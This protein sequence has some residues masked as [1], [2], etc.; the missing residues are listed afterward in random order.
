[1]SETRAT[2][3]RLD[4]AA[5]IA[6]AILTACGGSLGSASDSVSPEPMASSDESA[7]ALTP[8]PQA[9]ATATSTLAPMLM[10]DDI[11]EVVTNDLVVRSLPEISDRSTIDEIRLNQEEGVLLFVLDGPVTADG[12]DW[13]RVAPF[14]SAVMD[15]LPS[16]LPGIGWVAAGRQGDDWIAPW[17]QACREPTVYDLL[18]TVPLKRLA[19]FGDRELTF[20]GQLGECTYVV[21]GTTSPSW[22]TTEFCTLY[23]DIPTDI[24]GPLHFHLDP[25]FFHSTPPPGLV[26]VTGIFDHPAAQTCEHHPLA[27]EEARP[28]EDVV[29]GCRAAFVATS[30]EER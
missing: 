12:F 27:G 14:Y 23:A 17:T 19:C 4:L 24:A 5:V 18:F 2:R 9:T 15:I 6:L 25:D 11:A 30:V 13:Y 26:R 16:P 10:A 21:P 3:R 7:V 8:T 22:L 20:E 28:P 1:M 29:L